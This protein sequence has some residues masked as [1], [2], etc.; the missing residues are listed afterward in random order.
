MT[1][2]LR[3]TRA[4]RVLSDGNHKAFIGITRPGE[5]TRITLR[6]GTTRMPSDGTVRVIASTD[7]ER[8]EVLEEKTRDGSGLR[9]PGP[10]THNG[11]ALLH[12][13]AWASQPAW[14]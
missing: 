11:Q 3:I 4:R 14:L 10:V 9:D 2:G 6:I 5:A 13:G 8:W 1:T 12:R 7:L